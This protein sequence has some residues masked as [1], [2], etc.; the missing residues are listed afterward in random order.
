MYSPIQLLSALALIFFAAACG[1]MAGQRSPIDASNSKEAWNAVNDPLNMRDQYEVRFALLPVSGELERKPWSDTY[2][3]SYQGG[4][5]NRWNVPSGPDAWSY[6]LQTEAQVQTMTQ[7]ALAMLSP[8]EKYDIFVGQYTFPLVSHERERTHAND[9]GWY[10]LCHGWAP[11]ALNFK[12]PNPV[13]VE[14]AAGIK[15]P[16]GSSDVKALLLFAQQYGEDSSMAGS[17]CN[18]DDTDR[19]SD[20]ECQDINAGSFHVILTNQIGILGEGFVAEV[21]RA[22]QVWNQPVFGFTSE[23][24]SQSS[25]VYAS[26]APGTVSIVTVRS[27]MRYIIEMAPRWEP[28]PYADF[29]AQATGRQYDYTLELNANG[30]IL[31]GEWLS[32][33]HPDFFW[34]QSTPTFS[35]YFAQL[36]QIYEAATREMP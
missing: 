9:P 21:N 27:T 36:S 24:V 11:A 13:V 20:P 31:G 30:E 29:P 26:A 19:A 35:G 1:Q 32:A 3:P 15:V 6:E 2:W 22:A 14:G 7:E 34:T 25:E 17:R 33:D 18:F 16:F 28:I 23:V 8:A 4:L 10:G 5:A 12:E